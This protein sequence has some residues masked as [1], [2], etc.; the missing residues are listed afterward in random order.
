MNRSSWGTWRHYPSPEPEPDF[1]PRCPRCG[2]FLDSA[3]WCFDQVI[4]GTFMDVAKE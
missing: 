1:G 2:T 3:P 4:E